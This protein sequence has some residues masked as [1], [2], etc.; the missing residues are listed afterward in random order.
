[1]GANARAIDRMIPIDVEPVS[2][3]QAPHARKIVRKRRRSSLDSL[4]FSRRSFR[5]VAFA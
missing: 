5:N 4:M 3:G 1:M 2:D